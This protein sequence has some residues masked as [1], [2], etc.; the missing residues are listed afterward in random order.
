MFSQD[1]LG[2]SEVTDLPIGVNVSVNRLSPYDL[3]GEPL[4]RPL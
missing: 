4:A 3:S 1:L 2:R